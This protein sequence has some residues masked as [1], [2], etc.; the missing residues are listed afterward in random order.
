MA[1]RIW[2]QALELRSIPWSGS[3]LRYLQVLRIL[4]SFCRAIFFEANVSALQAT[5][6]PSFR[7]L[8]PRRSGIA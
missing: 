8:L 6:S 7:P 1:V 3:W 5:K 2:D 4:I